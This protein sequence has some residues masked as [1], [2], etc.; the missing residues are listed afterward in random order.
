MAKRT[1]KSEIIMNSSEIIRKFIVENFLFGD[2][3]NFEDDTDIF[4]KSILDSTGIIELVSFVEET[5]GISVP[6]IEL[7]MDNFSSVNRIVKY[8]QSKVHPKVP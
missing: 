3:N 2:S 8:I 5:F 4:E 1:Y 6:N 7:V